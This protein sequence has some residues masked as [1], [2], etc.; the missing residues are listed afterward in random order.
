MGT[1]GEGRPLA[2]GGAAEAGRQATPLPPQMGWCPVGGPGHPPAAC[3]SSAEGCCAAG[4]CPAQSSPP[5]P[6]GPRL[7]P[8]R[9][10][11]AASPS[12][13]AA[14]SAAPSSASSRPA[15]PTADEASGNPRG[16]PGQVL[17]GRLSCCPCP[18]HPIGR[19]PFVPGAEGMSEHVGEA[20]HFRVTA[21][22]SHPPNFHLITKTWARSL[23]PLQPS[24]LPWSSDPLL[25]GHPLQ[26][27]H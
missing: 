14:P 19:A 1:K 15:P 9:R 22:R 6:G 10:C 18:P 13:A 3:F 27:H 23:P 7:C 24:P 17:T 8:G 12:S 21:I 5:A 2:A 4:P 11:S 25:N 16:R 26:P 20:L